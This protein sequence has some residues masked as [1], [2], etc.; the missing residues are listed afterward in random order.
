[1]GQGRQLLDTITLQVFVVQVL[2]AMVLGDGLETLAFGVRVAVLVEVLDVHRH[3]VRRPFIVHEGSLVSN[4]ELLR[5]NLGV[6]GGRHVGEVGSSFLGSI[7]GHHLPVEQISILRFHLHV[8]ILG[9]NG[10]G[11]GQSLEVGAAADY[12]LLAVLDSLVEVLVDDRQVRR[13][14]VSAEGQVFSRGRA[15]GGGRG[16]LC[17]RGRGGAGEL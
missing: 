10:H 12:L 16:G 9:K 6:E 8:N 1:M 7:Q 17:R 4:I 13:V 3:F 15:A 2:L 14:P 11:L 5:S